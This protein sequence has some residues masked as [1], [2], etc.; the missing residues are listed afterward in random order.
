MVTDFR[1]KGRRKSEKS[2]RGEREEPKGGTAVD[3]ALEMKQTQNLSPQMMQSMQILQMGSQELLEYI[4]ETMQENPVLES[5]SVEKGGED[6]SL[7]R[8]KL[9]WLASTDVQNSWYHRQDAADGQDPMD[10]LAANPLE[11]S[12]YY[13]LRSQVRMEELTCELAHALDYLMNA[14]DPNGW[15]DE[16]DADLAV[17]LGVSPETVKEAVALLQS[18]EPAGVGAHDLRECLLIQLDRRGEH[19]LAR[20]IAEKYLE[21]MS[22]DHYNLIS[23]ETGAGRSEVQAAC[24]LIRTLNPRPASGFSD[25][26]HL[27]YITPDLVVVSFEDHFEILTNDSYL[28]TLRMS[29]YYSRLYKETA[30]PQ[31]KEYL[32][33]KLRQARWVMYGVEQRRTTLMRCARCIVDRQELFFRCGPGHLQPMLLSDAATELEVHESTVSRAIRDKYIQCAHGIFPMGYFFSREL[34]DKGAGNTAEGARALLRSLIDGE[35]KT[36]PLSD[37][38]L[39]EL[40]TEKGVEISRRTVAKYRDELG[41]PSTAGR[42]TFR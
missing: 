31:V 26:V 12:L 17:H 34:G 37:Q 23:R 40:M 9:D 1:R 32:N 2:C 35:D 15:L 20:V 10:A 14:L 16:S 11:E 18:L 3:I 5:E 13:Y 41:I 25:R 30:D 42:K 36:K 24:D 8:R 27:P 28:P 19:G 39:S 22:R 38:R 33:S 6:M 4:E 29:G 21:A 7:L